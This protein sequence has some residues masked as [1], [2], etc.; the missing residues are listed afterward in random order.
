MTTA[1][2]TDS[3]TGMDEAADKGRDTKSTR[4]ARPW[5]T[6][7]L[8]ELVNFTEAAAILG[9]DRMTLHRWLEPGSG[10]VDGPCFGP[11]RTYMIP[12]HQTTNGRVWVRSDVERFAA[13]VGGKP[14]GRRPIRANTAEAIRREMANL[15]AQLEKV[16]AREAARKRPRGSSSQ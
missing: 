7:R 14:L 8:P 16:Q 2:T 5:R 12:P 13:E 1:A 4:Q 10:L 3:V 11:H 9:K 15:E 6:P